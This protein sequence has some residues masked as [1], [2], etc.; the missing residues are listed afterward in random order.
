[1]AIKVDLLPTERK[2]FGFD[3]VIAI[4]IV[5][6]ALAVV[7]FYYFGVK[8]EKDIADK[9]GQ[10]TK[11]DQDIVSL[12]SQ[13]PIIEKLK[14]ENQ[15]LENQINTVKSLR[16]DPIRYSNLLDEISSL[17]PNNMW[18]SSLSIEP[19]QSKVMMSG[20]A[21]AMP[22]IKPLESISGFMKSVQRSKYFRD[23]SLSSTSK[24]AVTVNGVTYTSYSF[25]IDMT[26]D[27][28]A[29]E[30]ADSGSGGTGNPDRT[31]SGISHTVEEGS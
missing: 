19:G 4:L 10:I 8:L 18:L 11:V 3:P 14:K 6:I 13:L 25:G 9:R 29:A 22:G 31:A 16:Y 24:G 7:V 2:K 30:K 5:L 27:P 1:M 17:L 28:K 20:T 15:E 21:A 23:A 26:Y 12:Q